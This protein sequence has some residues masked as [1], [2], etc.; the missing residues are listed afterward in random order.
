[1]DPMNLA[2]PEISELRERHRHAEIDRGLGPDRGELPV[3]H[4]LSGNE[5]THRRQSLANKSPADSEA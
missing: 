2:P 1:M 3:E 4:P 5:E